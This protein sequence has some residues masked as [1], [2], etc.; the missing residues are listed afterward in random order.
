[1]FH[2]PKEYRKKADFY[3]YMIVF[4]TIVALIVIYIEKIATF[5]GWILGISFP[6]ILGLGFAFV[7]NIISNAILR[8]LH[9]LFH[10]KET[11]GKRRITNIVAILLVLGLAAVFLITIVPQVFISVEKLV[12]DL[13]ATLIRLKEQAMKLTVRIPAL[14]QAIAA[15]DLHQ[16]DNQEVLDRLESLLDSFL[17]DT[18]MVDRISRIISTTISWMT[19]LFLALCF[20]IFVLFNKKKFISDVRNFFLAFLPS[21]AY[22]QGS[23]IYHIVKKT[24]ARYIAG[25][26]L[27][28]LILGS[29]V[30]LGS[31][32]LGLPYSLLCGFIVA[33]GALVPMFGALIAAI[34]CALFIM[35]Q[36]PAEGLTFLVMFIAIQQVEGNFIYPNVV[37]K[38]IGFPPMYVIVAITLG[39]SIAGVIGMVIFIP[40]CSSIYTLLQEYEKKHINEE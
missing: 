27:E 18:K 17:G 15:I 11:K 40:L 7:F 23:H 24:F 4:I 30:T 25:T 34:C 38:T 13:P 5:I 16:V 20:S 32:L 19:T 22:K 33:I 35:I 21:T 8:I 28:C 29:L 3:K 10:V 9:Q 1:M 6:F 36:S 12:S 37:G 31:T 26:L 2:V 14:H 39:A